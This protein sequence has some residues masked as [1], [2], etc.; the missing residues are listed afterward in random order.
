MT[1]N[2]NDRRLPTIFLGYPFELDY[3]RATVER[4]SADLAQVVIASDILRGMSLLAKIE[5]MMA[6]ADLCIFDLTMHNPNVA[7][8]FGIARGR[9]YAWAIL[10]CTDEALNPR[11]ERES[12]VFSDVKGSDSILYS[13]ETNLELQLRRLLP[14]YLENIARGRVNGNIVSATRELIDEQAVIVELGASD[15]LSGMLDKYPIN[16]AEKWRRTA[17]D[18]AFEVFRCPTPGNAYGGLLNKDIVCNTS[19]RDWPEA[20]GGLTRSQRESMMIGLTGNKELGIDGWLR[21]D[22]KAPRPI[23]V[24]AEPPY[25]PSL[26]RQS[27]H[28]RLGNSD[29]L[30]VRAITEISRIERGSGRVRLGAIFPDRWPASQSPDGPQESFTTRCVPYHVS[31]QAIIVCEA[32]NAWHLLLA[33]VNP[34][35]G[36]ITGGWGATMATQMWGPDRAGNIEPW[37]SAPST[38]NLLPRGPQTGDETLEGT[39]RRGLDAEFQ[40]D[41]QSDLRHEPKLLLAAV[42]QDMYF[43][44]FIY[45]VRVPFVLEE[46]YR[47][48]IR[49]PEF[50]HN[51]LLAAY[52]LTGCDADGIE[53]NGPTRLARLLAQAQFDAGPHLRPEPRASGEVSGPWHVS[54]RLRIYALG[55][56]L[57]PREFPRLVHIH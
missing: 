48:W 5:Q 2:P 22:M 54:S 41:I 24:L 10:Y 33:N 49:S 16:L 56:H 40:I 19:A 37:W 23:R 6:E 43:I 55:M 52:Q 13:D 9:D 39:L 21:D 12:S 31:I 35:R 26:A 14:E 25:P 3:I 11:P 17:I 30:T 15:V 32:P 44:T 4:A 20:F 45:I 47:R 38:D 18:G 28:L 51:G 27:L 34:E 46:L 36:A 1:T 53:L 42:E 50:H 57:W 8:E 29:Y 7:V